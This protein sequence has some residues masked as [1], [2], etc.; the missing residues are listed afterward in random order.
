MPYMDPM[1]LDTINDQ[2]NV[3]K[4]SRH[5]EMLILSPTFLMK[6]AKKKNYFHLLYQLFFF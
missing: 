5:S 3:K 6:T 2:P 1:G 4:A